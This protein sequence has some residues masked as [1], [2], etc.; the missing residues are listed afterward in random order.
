[1]E[2]LRPD[3]IL[4]SISAGVVVALIDIPIEISLAA[5]IFSGALAG[6]VASGI[7]LALVGVMVIG[8]VVALTSSFPGTVALPQD[9]PAAILAL[10]AVAIVGAVPRS[11]APEDAFLTVV[12][13]IA[14][15]SVLTGLFFLVLGLCKL[16]TLVRYIPHPVVGGFLAGSGWLLVVG[17]LGVLTDASLSLSEIPSL[18]QPQV[19]LRWLPALAFAVLLLFVL[20]RTSHSLAL[21]ATIAAGIGI[22][23]LVLWLTSTPVSEAG[24]QGWLLGPFPQGGL[25]PPMALSDLRQV[26]WSSIF[27]QAGNVATI[28]VMSLVSL[29]L[30][31]SALELTIRRDMDLNR[32]LK[33]AGLANLLAGFGAG[34]PGFHALSL[35]SLGHR[36][37][38]ESRLVGIVPAVLCGVVLLFGA[39]ALSFF[40]KPVLGA[41][42]LFLGLG[43]LV[44][45]LY[46]AWF[47]LSRA[48]YAI[49][50]AILL[51][52]GSVGVLA[53]VAVGIVLAVVLFVVSYSRVGV[54]RHALSG[55][56]YSSNVDRPQAQYT[57]LR[58]KG[59]WLYILELQGFI[60]FGTAHRL[61]DRVRRRIDDPDLP[62]P[63][64][65]VLDFR[66][67]RGLD[68]SAVL[69][70]A[71][72]KQI[73]AARDMVLVL[74]HLSASTERLLSADVLTDE[75][76]ASWRVHA[77]LD[78]GVE[79][80]EEQILLKATAEADALPVEDAEEE[81]DIVQLP[82]D[83]FAV[84]LGAL[85]GA[86]QAMSGAETPPS[87]RATGLGTY[88]ERLEVPEYHYLI[89][90]GDAPRGLYIVEKGQVTALLERGDERELRLRKMGPGSIVGEMGLYLDT[91]ATATVR[92]RQ[93]STLYFLSK[94]ALERMEKEEPGLATTLHRFV[95]QL[96]GERLSRANDTIGAVFGDADL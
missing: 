84:L 55:Q 62:P 27:S 42:L 77:D 31:I 2:Q 36:M 4:P 39:T 65:I 64:F 58:S 33:S 57:V 18:F 9:S 81:S 56:N 30:N 60:F 25:W 14:L 22:F 71:R 19:L 16:G 17:A 12:V 79:W 73:A 10:A 7:G 95:V 75:D 70:F 88:V 66:Q 54:V 80:C 68:A 35:S 6:Y 51:A 50:V 21:P 24:A 59:D 1:M 37:K 94:E 48:E 47:K 89:R 28:L 11:A 40:P 34:L 5:L 63:R 23:Y 91:P 67:V 76:R 86:D 82:G 90:Q 52:I 44:E 38:A 15:T 87:I 83:R 93:P 41:V 13:A 32:E 43:F 45:W 72:M 96:L 20:R 61:L 8:F 78:H 3:R 49:V 46:D 53:G 26:H 85:T 74:T 69:S 29:L 92:T